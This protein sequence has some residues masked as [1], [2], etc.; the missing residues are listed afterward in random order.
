MAKEILQIRTLNV[1]VTL[2]NAEIEKGVAAVQRYADSTK[3]VTYWKIGQYI[4]IHL[5]Y[6]RNTA[7]Y[8][9]SF[10]LQLA[11]ELGLGVRSL[12]RALQFYESYP[13]SLLRNSYRYY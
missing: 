5:D 13:H 4:K 11:K 12:Y 8:G 10:F 3:V 1:L 6:K 7:H 9:E 2:I